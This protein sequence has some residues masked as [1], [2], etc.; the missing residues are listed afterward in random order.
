ME[1]MHLQLV[2][3]DGRK[4]WDRALNAG[5]TE[6]MAYEMQP[7]GDQWGMVRDPFGL[8][9]AILEPGARA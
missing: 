7:W 8:Q 1:T 3:G 2:V 6:V 4:W 5:C 9:W